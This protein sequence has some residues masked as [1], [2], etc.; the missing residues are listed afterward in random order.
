MSKEEIKVG[1][2]NAI[3]RGE[4]IEKAIQTLLSAGYNPQEIQEVAGSI[5]LSSTSNLV[6]TQEHKPLPSESQVQ[7]YKPLPSEKPTQENTGEKIR[8]KPSLTLI[9]LLIVVLLVSLGIA[10]FMFF[11]ET[12][13]NTLFPQTA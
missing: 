10:A 5:N 6:K 4:S 9:I 3:N 8:K 7:G 13:L 1:L 11:G 12:I 2:T